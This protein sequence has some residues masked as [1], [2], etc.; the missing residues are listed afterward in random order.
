[1][2]PA[3]FILTE[4]FNNIEREPFSSDE[5]TDMYKAMYEGQPVVAKVL[6][7]TLVDDPG[8]V[9]KVSG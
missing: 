9:R 3:S 4:G 6:K 5:F 2:L 7:A 8:N 1:V